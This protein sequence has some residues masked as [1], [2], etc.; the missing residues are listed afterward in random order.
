MSDFHVLSFDTSIGRKCVDYTMT[1][2]PYTLY[3]SSLC[4]AKMPSEY[5]QVFIDGDTLL[6]KA[7]NP[8]DDGALKSTN[9]SMRLNS[10]MLIDFIHKQS[11]GQTC[12]VGDYDEALEGLV[13]NIGSSHA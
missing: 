1:L 4:R 2:Y 12:F 13:F 8:N 5:Y 3:F 7:C 9:N 10:K 6:I 11:G